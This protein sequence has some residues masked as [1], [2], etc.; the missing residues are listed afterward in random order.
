[1]TLFQLNAVKIPSSRL[2]RVVHM[3]IG[4]LTS[5]LSAWN[6][7]VNVAVIIFLHGGGHK[8]IHKAH[9]LT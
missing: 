5:D 8:Y 7:N 9:I 2:V 4:R 6:L 3:K 1:M